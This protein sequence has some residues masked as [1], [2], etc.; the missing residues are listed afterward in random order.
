M[1]VLEGKW[2]GYDISKEAVVEYFEDI[3]TTLDK[4]SDLLK[5]T[6]EDIKEEVNHP[7]HYKSDSGM[8]V[9]DVIKAFTSG[10]DGCEATHTGNIIKY[11]CRWKKKGGIKDLKKL[12]WYVTDLIIE[13]EKKGE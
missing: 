9:I 4:R 1:D 12:Q 11:A 10:L 8:E 5:E 7:M 2:T 3:I 13:L 6:K